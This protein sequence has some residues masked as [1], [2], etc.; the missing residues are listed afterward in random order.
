M[1]RP[2]HRHNLPVSIERGADVTLTLDLRNADGEAVAASAASLVIR[3]GLTVRATIASATIDGDGRITYDLPAATS[4]DWP[5]TDSLLLE[6][7]ATVDGTV[8]RYRV[9]GA[10]CLWTYD[11]TLTA[12]DVFTRYP[13]LRA[14]I[15]AA[16]VAAIL[17]STSGEV[18]RRILERGRRPYL[19]ADSWAVADAH[20]DLA[21]WRIMAAADTA[22]N[23]D[24]WRRAAEAHE[25]SYATRWG[26]LSF[27]YDLSESGDV[28]EAAPEP[29]SPVIVLTAGRSGGFWGRG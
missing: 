22:L 4:A 20:L 12:D 23:D 5:L 10:V 27:R 17:A 8:Y 14:A 21:L 9:T 11:S 26:A 28:S 1:A 15:D 7:S 24:R 16:D 6:W 25:E 3:D 13:G 29:A 19:I 2:I 18:Q